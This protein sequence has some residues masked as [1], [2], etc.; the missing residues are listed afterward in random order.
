MSAAALSVVF[1]GIMLLVFEGLDRYDNYKNNKNSRRKEEIY[2]AKIDTEKSLDKRYRK[3][4]GPIRGK[5]I[6]PWGK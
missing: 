1:A 5:K 4:S 6:I 2:T 3:A